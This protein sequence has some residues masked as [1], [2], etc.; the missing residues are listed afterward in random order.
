MQETQN[1]CFMC[2]WQAIGDL[3]A[4]EVLFPRD[5]GTFSGSKLWL[6]YEMKLIWVWKLQNC[7]NRQKSAFK[8]EYVSIHHWAEQKSETVLGGTYLSATQARIGIKMMCYFYENMWIFH[9]F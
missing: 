3:T 4:P 9:P 5:V 6:E 7:H 1:T 2:D 8:I